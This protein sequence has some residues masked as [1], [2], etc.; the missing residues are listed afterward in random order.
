METIKQKN[1]LL[2]SHKLRMSIDSA[3]ASSAGA[4]ILLSIF[5]DMLNLWW[6]IPSTIMV[7]V[8]IV[9]WWITQRIA[10]EKE[11]KNK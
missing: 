6:G 1:K 5:A 9:G 3:I 2:L 7:A 4:L 8:A 10:T 11:E